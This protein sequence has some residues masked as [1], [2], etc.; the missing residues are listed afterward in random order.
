MPFNQT[1]LAKNADCFLANVADI[2][3]ERPLTELHENNAKILRQLASE[4]ALLRKLILGARE[5]D[6]L[7]AK[8]EEDLVEDKIVLWDNLDN[9]IRIRLR[10]S[11]KP[12]Q[13]LAHSHRFSFTNLVMRGQ[14][15]HWHYDKLDTFDEKTRLEDVVTSAQHVDRQGDIFSIHH[16]AMHS[17]PFLDFG[18]ISLVLRG[19]PVKERAPVM[20]KEARGRAEFIEQGGDLEVEPDH[21]GEGSFFWRVGEERESR[22]R[23]AERRMSSAKLDYWIESLEEFGIL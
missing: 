21:A 14:Y 12:Q 9:G 17:T 23:R 18:T 2:D 5:D 1:H 20:F 7:W 19:N 8:C 13:R 16:E 4:K 15:V 3:W 6:Y 22:Q 10:M 11:T